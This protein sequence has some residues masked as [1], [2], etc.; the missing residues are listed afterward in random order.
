LHKVNRVVGV[1]V[2]IA[3]RTE[4]L[5]VPNRMRATLRQWFDVISMKFDQCLSA[6][7]A[8]TLLFDVQ[9]VYLLRG[10]PFNARMTSDR[11]LS[12]RK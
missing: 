1:L 6:C 11:P 2:Q 4:Q 5:Q 12:L 10:D 3:R 8:A 9:V 7:R